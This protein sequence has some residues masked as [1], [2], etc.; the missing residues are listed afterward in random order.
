MAVFTVYVASDSSSSLAAT[1][2]VHFIGDRFGWGALLLGPIWLV[3][4]RLWWALLAYFVAVAILV[5]AAGL[6]HLS[7]GIV[8]PV[9]LIIGIFVGLEGGALR[10]FALTRRRY[11]IADIIAA[12][13]REAAEREFFRRWPAAAATQVGR[14]SVPPASDNGQIIGVFP[15]AGGVS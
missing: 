13:N 9:L 4:H 15:T 3:W 11:R 6:L 2:R 10:D 1:D 8:V 14:P 5:F 12:P 7:A